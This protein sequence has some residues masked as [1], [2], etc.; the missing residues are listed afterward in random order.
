MFGFIMFDPLYL[1]MLAPAMLLAMWAQF[2]VKS[3]FARA[4]EMPS[5]SGLTGAEA[6]HRILRAHGLQRVDVQPAEGFLSDHYDPRAKV[7]RLSPDVYSGRSLAAVGVAAHEAGHAIQDAAGYG[8]LKLR[9]GIVPMA[10]V[11]SNLS[12][13]IF[14]VGMIL[15]ATAIGRGLVLLGIGLFSLTV[16]FQLVNLPVEFDASRRARAVLVANGIVGPQQDAEVGRVLNAAA[17][18]YV[19]ATI[20]AILTLVYLLLRSGLLGGGRDE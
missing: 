13:I 1:V 14:F 4:Q 7:L 20:S 11:G 2:K 15:S 3:A 19:A 5:G 9:N 10:A 8:P 12:F 6:A 16:V 17:M 18:T